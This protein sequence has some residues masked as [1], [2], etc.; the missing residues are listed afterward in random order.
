MT[1]MEKH[2]NLANPVKHFPRMNPLIA[3]YLVL[4][5]LDRAE[6]CILVLFLLG[7]DDENIF[8]T[9][10][11]I[12][13]YL[14]RLLPPRR[15]SGEKPAQQVPEN[16]ISAHLKHMANLGIF[17]RISPKSIRINPFIV[18]KVKKIPGFWEFE[19]IKLNRFKAEFD[20]WLESRKPFAD[21]VSYK[22]FI[23]GR[24]VKKLKRRMYIPL[25]EHN[26]IVENL[27]NIIMQHIETNKEKDMR[28]VQLEDDLKYK[29]AEY[30]RIEAKMNSVEDTIQQ[31]LKELRKHDPDKAD[32][33]HLKVVHGGK[34][35]QSRQLH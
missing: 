26:A 21:L 25:S 4:V 27:T 17:H 11:P 24:R 5:E 18:N 19:D 13:R 6:V 10:I 22:R 14:Q 1:D 20:E 28:I 34:S 12:R 29:S 32:E 16:K 30:L 15:K 8:E 23:D 3:V 35:E 7:M 31:I 33:I 2:Q 9:A